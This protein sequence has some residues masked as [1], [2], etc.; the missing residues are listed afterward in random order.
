[1]SACDSRGLGPVPGGLGVWLTGART[2]ATP[3]PCRCTRRA[4][5]SRAE[6]SGHWLWSR[7]ESCVAITGAQPQNMSRRAQGEVRG[8][9]RAGA[10]CWAEVGLLLA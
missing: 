1:M 8:G 3:C 9:G 6:E 10:G 4:E 7:D 5:C 2:E